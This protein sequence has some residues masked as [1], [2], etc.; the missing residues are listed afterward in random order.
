MRYGVSLVI[1]YYLYLQ[2]NHVSSIIYPVFG[3]QIPRYLC[4]LASFIFNK[5]WGASIPLINCKKTKNNNKTS[6]IHCLITSPLR[7]HIPN[8]QR[9]CQVKSRLISIQSEDKQLTSS[10]CKREKT[11]LHVSLQEGV[12]MKQ[13]PTL[14]LQISYSPLSSHLIDGMWI[15]WSF[16]LLI[17]NVLMYFN[18]AFLQRSYL[19]FDKYWVPAVCQAQCWALGLAY[20]Y[21]K[22]VTHQHFMHCP[23]L[24]E[25]S[26][27]KRV[28]INHYDIDGGSGSTGCY[29]NT[30]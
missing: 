20:N 3:T 28:W 23:S 25:A 4:L 13:P 16:Y 1:I 8:A 30:E 24:L 6:S 2:E 7:F 15:Y 18:V 19:S 5:N 26:V 9:G 11:M 10:H 17:T 27:K 29:E 22:Y 21:P 14:H 12:L